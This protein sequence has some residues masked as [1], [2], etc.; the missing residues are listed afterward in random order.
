MIEVYHSSIPFSEC[1]RKCHDSATFSPPD[2]PDC[3]L[4]IK[5]E[6]IKTLQ[7]I[8]MNHDIKLPRL[9]PHSFGLKI[10]LI[11]ILLLCFQ[12]PMQMIR[13]TIQERQWRQM[14]VEYDIINTRGGA[15]AFGGPIMVVP[16]ER[17][18]P[19]HNEE[20]KITMYDTLK[21]EIY[22]LPDSLD[23]KGSSD[24]EIKS[25][26]I[27]SVPV[28]TL[29]LEGQGSF[30]P[31]KILGQYNP[32]EILWDQISIQ[33]SYPSLKGMKKV[34]PFHWDGKEIVFQPGG[35][36]LSVYQGVMSVPV[37]LREGN[38]IR[39]PFQFSQEIMG[40]ESISFLPLARETRISLKSDWAS[41][42]FN[43]YYLP[44]R[45]EIDEEGFSAEWEINYLSRNFPQSWTS[46]SA[47]VFQQIEETSF[48]V[49]F[50]PVVT[51]YD[52]I[53]RTV[54][55]GL[56]FLILPFMTF[57]LFEI[58]GKHRIHP[59]QY[60]LA[61]TGNLLFYLLLLSL[62]EHINF[63]GAYLA[64]AL[65]VT[66]MMTS[67]AVS[68]LKARRSGLIFL[69]VMILSYGYLYFV[70]QSE[71]YA[72]LM[73]SAGLFALISFIMYLTRKVEWYRGGNREEL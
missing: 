6:K 25:R 9:N 58:I 34:K 66:V 55:Y 69:P 61:G 35:S 31:G 7:E 70:L 46:G 29:L 65:A 43:G 59:V 41:P 47:G 39:Y 16:R 63:N 8:Y 26:G 27:Y 10:L 60:I 37:S 49:R 71:D 17:K 51:S 2:L 30:S 68:V 73:G 45:N 54:K 53:N 33:F 42:S 23:I 14:D 22:I 57:F 20:G 15:S 13:S 40:G 28:F 3:S 56:L 52:K 5:T 64:A 32:D 1:S 21:D 11:S 18:I 24:S 38:A 36:S 67:Y 19:L 50:F 72:L 4:T 62:S 12:L 44:D 48:G